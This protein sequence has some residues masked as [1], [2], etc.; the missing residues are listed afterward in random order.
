MVERVGALLAACHW[1]VHESLS[2]EI[3]ALATICNFGCEESTLSELVENDLQ[4]A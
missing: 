1:Q 4:F 2:E 3:Y